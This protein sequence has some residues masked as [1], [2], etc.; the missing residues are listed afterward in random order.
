MSFQKIALSLVHVFI[1]GIVLFCSLWIHLGIN[2]EEKLL[3]HLSLFINNLLTMANLPDLFW[4]I[5]L[6]VLLT[7]I[8]VS[9]RIAGWLGLLSLS[10]VFLSGIYIENLFSL[11]LLVIGMVLGLFAP[12]Q[13]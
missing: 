7:S 6:F 8:I 2:P 10:L 13:E 4:F 9:F 3:E 12:L 1:L 5:P 11:V